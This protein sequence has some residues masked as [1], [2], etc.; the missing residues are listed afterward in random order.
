MHLEPDDLVDLAEGTRSE[1]SV[2]H[3]AA[4]A[5][6]R[7]QLAE[8]RAMIATVAE[9]EIPEP[10]PLFWNQMSARV[11]GNIASESRRLPAWLEIA[12][13]RRG[14]M[15]AAAVAA[16][17][18][19]AIVLGSRLTAP[20]PA[21]P[22]NQSALVALPQVTA[23]DPN[24][25]AEAIGDAGFDDASLML[26][27]SLTSSIDVDAARDAVL[28]TDDSADHA[29]AHMPA[30]ELRELERLLKAELVGS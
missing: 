28:A 15:P 4:C 10:S 11:A 1:S 9:I 22:E 6:C 17:A 19:V 14:W 29:V 27:A 20:P 7:R 8:M 18:L 26:V 21:P 25:G 24:A 16:A 12:A 13:W 2:P 5:D 23:P 3:L 30:A